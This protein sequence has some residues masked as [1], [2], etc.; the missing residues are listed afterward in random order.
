MEP[1]AKTEENPIQ[2]NLA[3]HAQ[4]LRTLSSD[5]AESMRQNQGKAVKA[6]IQEEERREEE[7]ENLSPA[8]T[9]NLT[10]IISGVV[11]SIVAI[12]IIVYALSKVTTE[13]PTVV[14][15][16]VPVAR[17]IIRS[18]ATKTVPIGGLRDDQIAQ[19][20][21][22]IATAAN[23]FGTITEIVITDVVGTTSKRLPATVFLSAIDAHTAK[24]FIQSISPEFMFGVY[25]HEKS[26][27]FLS[28]KSTSRDS[29]VTGMKSWEAFLLDD[30]AP[31]IG[32]DTKNDP[33]DFAHAAFTDTLIE[34]R[35]TRAI[36]KKDG[37]PVLFYAFLDEGTVV[38]TSDTK[39]F[40]EI[41]RRFGQK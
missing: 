6:A 38:I 24:S 22:K 32:F 10:Y 8:S 17:A 28:I 12:G 34:N 20:V 25:T 2:P 1:L 39:T 41:I 3:K 26:E 29:L 4:P 33:E 15:T 9:K 18:D 5:M 35:S 37:T 16:P 36:V 11:I 30:L 21:R 14:V 31:L 19:E 13:T 23:R 40:A 7:K 27:V